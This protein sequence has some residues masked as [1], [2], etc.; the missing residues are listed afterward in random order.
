MEIGE[1]LS[2]TVLQH[3]L[4][5]LKVPMVTLTFASSK[6]K[7]IATLVTTLALKVVELPGE[8]EKSQ[9]ILSKCIDDFQDYFLEKIFW[10][11]FS[12]VIF[13]TNHF[14]GKIFWTKVFQQD[15]FDEIV[16]DNILSTRFFWR[17]ILDVFKIWALFKASF[18]IQ[19]ASLIL[20]HFYWCPTT[21]FYN[22]HQKSHKINALCSKLQWTDQYCSTLGIIQTLDSQP[23]NNS[24]HWGALHVL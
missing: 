11:R 16:F 21:K 19:A 3:K 18:R 4:G 8:Q 22:W 7:W 6:F 13:L 9:M 23:T 10:M 17:D 12:D 15:C 2:L 14:F 24:A 1:T 20:L 5:L